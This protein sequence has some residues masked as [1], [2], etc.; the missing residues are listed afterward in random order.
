MDWKKKLGS[1][2]FWA[3]ASVFITSILIIFGASTGDIEKVAAIVTSG[4]AVISY[5][6]IEG[7]IDKAAVKKT[8]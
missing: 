7:S 2:K 8:E 1:R 5:I 6:L 3:L 4:G